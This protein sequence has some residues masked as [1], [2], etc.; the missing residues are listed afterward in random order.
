MESDKPPPRPGPRA[1]QGQRRANLTQSR[2]RETKRSLAQAAI[3]LWRTKGF[4]DTTVADICQAA[5]VSKALF[6][7]YFPRKEDALLE[8][9]VVSTR[10]ARKKMRE[11]LARPYDVAEVIVAVLGTM[12]RAMRRSPPDL[13]IE[14]ILEGHRAEHRALQEGRSDEHHTTRFM[15]LE[16]IERAQADGKLPPGLDVLHVARVAQ[17]LMETGAR[18]WAVGEYGDRGF[19]EVVGR[20]IAAY[21]A[22]CAARPEPPRS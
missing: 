20:D 13:I 4:A 6:Y 3:A 17:S 22:G 15:F 10:E 9:G 19:A 7:F 14:T 12:E 16:L 18:H 11:L 2:S 21:L 1:D 8:A 5:G